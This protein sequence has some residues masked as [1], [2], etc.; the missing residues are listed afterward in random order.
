MLSGSM[1]IKF[2]SGKLP[3]D[4]FRAGLVVCRLSPNRTLVWKFGVLRFA[5]EKLKTLSH[6]KNVILSRCVT[7]ISLMLSH[8]VS[9]LPASLR[10][11]GAAKSCLDSKDSIEPETAIQMSYEKSAFAGILHEFHTIGQ[12]KARIGQE[13][14]FLRQL[15]KFYSS[16][17]SPIEKL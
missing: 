4:C 13:N 9:S 14:S 6:C 1:L 17:P 11:L 12:G 3:R 16:T 2:W 10:G 15:W 7:I 8:P 5:T